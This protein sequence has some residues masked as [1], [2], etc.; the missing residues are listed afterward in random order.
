MTYEFEHSVVTSAN[1]D[2]A[3]KVWTDVSNWLFDKSIESVRLNG[4]FATGT[5]GVTKP[6]GGEQVGAR[7]GAGREQG[8]DDRN[9]RQ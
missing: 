8:G 7:G 6:A 9:L 2:F 3:W 4:P 1:V 5:T